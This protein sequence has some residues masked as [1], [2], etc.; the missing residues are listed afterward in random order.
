MGRPS[1]EEMELILEWD[2][3]KV[4]SVRRVDN[5]GCGGEGPP[6]QLDT[7][8][9]ALVDQHLEHCISSHSMTPPRPR[10][11]FEIE[12]RPTGTDEFTVRR[13]TLQ[14]HEAGVKH[15]FDL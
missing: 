14:Q 8:I 6:E 3:G 7:P 4:V 2:D 5:E 12:V 11:L 9:Q 15:D 10:C 13:C 1:F